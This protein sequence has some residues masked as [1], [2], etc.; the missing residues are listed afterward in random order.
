[1]FPSYLKHQVLTHNI[2]TKRC[3]LA[4]NIVPLG[5]YGIGDSQYDTTWVT[6]SIGAWR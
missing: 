3:S 6:P 4:F 5:N 2:D 1:M